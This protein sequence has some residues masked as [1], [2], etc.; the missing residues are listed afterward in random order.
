VSFF[1]S[2]KY[3]TA[4]WSFTEITEGTIPKGEGPS[5]MKQLEHIS[6]DFS[7][8]KHEGQCPF[9]QS[10]GSN[11]V[12]EK[13]PFQLMESDTGEAWSFELSAVTATDEP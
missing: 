4:A 2:G 12:P 9:W 5:S 11:S 3:F 6:N 13:W 1:H 7:L 10:L 8:V